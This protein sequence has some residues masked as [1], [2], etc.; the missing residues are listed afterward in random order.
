MTSSNY[1]NLSE[2]ELDSP[3]YR[4]MPTHRLLEALESKKLVLIKPK[5]WD[6]PFENQLLKAKVLTAE[7]ETGYFGF[8]DSVYGLCWTFHCE[9]DAMWRIY[10][11][12]KQGVKVKTT[13]RKL[14]ETL[15][16][17]TANSPELDCFIGR[18]KYLEEADLWSWL[19]NNNVLDNPSVSSIAESLLY[20]RMEFSHENE[21]RLVYSPSYNSNSFNC[22]KTHSFNIDPNELFDE[23]IF[24]PRM[25]SELYKAYSLAVREKKFTKEVAQ[26]TLYEVPEDL[27]I[28]LTS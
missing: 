16:K 10:S 1:I 18:V 5:N 4:I 20:K 25:N 27:I 21:V 6:D 14:L 11:S 8:R 19:R 28:R 2:E 22:P 17:A 24:D 9:T 7:G 3:I 15:M 26:S 13:P 12:E 23:I